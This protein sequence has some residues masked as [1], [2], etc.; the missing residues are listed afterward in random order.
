MEAE[1]RIVTNTPS[2]NDISV[3]SVYEERDGGT[4]EIK[5][6]I[7][8]RAVSTNASEKLTSCTRKWERLA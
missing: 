1:R 6:S 7:I 5:G 4:T 2:P 3:I 8:F